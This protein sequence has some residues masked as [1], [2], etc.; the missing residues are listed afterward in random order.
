MLTGLARCLSRRRYNDAN[1]EVAILCNH[2][3]TVS[4]AAQ[5]TLDASKDKLDWL[6]TQKQELVEMKAFLTKGKENKARKD[7][8]KEAS[9]EGSG[10]RQ[11]FSPSVA[12]K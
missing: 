7:A 12:R 4:K 9:E 8:R 10:S 1:R 2:Q 6:K 5:A 11:S 3:K